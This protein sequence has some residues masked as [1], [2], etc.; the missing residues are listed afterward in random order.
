MKT[1]RRII[2]ETRIDK[3]RNERI[4]EI[5]GIQ[6]ITS[7]VQRRTKW[8]MHISRNGGRSLGKEGPWRNPCREEKPRS[9]NEKMERRT[10]V[11]RSL[12]YKKRRRSIIINLYFGY[13]MPIFWFERLLRVDWI[14]G[15]DLEDY[16]VR[17]DTWAAGTVRR[18]QGR[19]SN[20][21]LW[22]FLVSMYLCT[23]L[24]AVLVVIGGVEQTP[25]PGVEG[26]SFVQVMCSGCDTSLKSGTQCY[27]CG[28][29]FHNGCG[30]VKVQLVDSGKWNCERCK[31][32]RF[33]LLEVKLK[34]ALIAIEDLKLR[35]KRLEEQLIAA[36]AGNEFWR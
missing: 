8:S 35:N 13:T 26:E 20:W 36:A 30:N 4:R 10:G 33:C 1:L 15:C 31:W 6:T 22:S 32:E 25:G 9:A 17:V 24:L 29:W 5:C 21:Q 28:R 3:I 2:N 11:N 19:K 16:G 14:M 7:W 23:A 18:D 27:T 34:N 12:T